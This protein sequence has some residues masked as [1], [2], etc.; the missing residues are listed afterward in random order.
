M[1]ELVAL[2]W[3]AAERAPTVTALERADRATPKYTGTAARVGCRPYLAQGLSAG[4][5][6]RLDQGKRLSR[7]TY[8]AFSQ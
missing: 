3:L 1:L 7:P 2:T 8:I 5:N 4:R 6:D